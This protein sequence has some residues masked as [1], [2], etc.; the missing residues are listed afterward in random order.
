MSRSRGKTFETGD[1]VDPLHTPRDLYWGVH[2][3]SCGHMMHSDCWQGFYKSV[4][5]KERR[6][7]RMGHHFTVDITKGKYLCPLCGC[8]SN[9]VLP[10]LPLLFNGQGEG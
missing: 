7:L 1:E 3:T 8:I 6:A 2:V 5:V 9:T 10:V 4:M